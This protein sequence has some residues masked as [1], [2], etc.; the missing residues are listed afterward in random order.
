MT[1]ALLV[2]LILL[3]QIVEEHITC[4]VGD[5]IDLPR[6]KY[7]AVRA[8]SADSQTSCQRWQWPTTFST[9]PWLY[10]TTK[11]TLFNYCRKSSFAD[12]PSAFIYTTVPI[13]STQAYYITRWNHESIIR[14]T[15]IV[16]RESLPSFNLTHF[17]H[18]LYGNTSCCISQLPV[19]WERANFDPTT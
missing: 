6:D 15:F 9:S 16:I 14:L 2:G 1:W 17:H 8:L 18:C 7:N 5:D 4:L 11:P 3:A 19:Q 13:T 10:T 12:P